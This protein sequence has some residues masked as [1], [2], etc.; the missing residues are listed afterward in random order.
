MVDAAIRGGLPTGNGSAAARR[1]T[2]AMV[3]G[4]ASGDLLASLMMGGL[5]ARLGDTMAYAGIGGKRMM[6]QG[7]ASRWP[8]ET[9]SVNGY[10]EVLGSLREILRTRRAVRDWLLAEPPQCF[11]GVDAPDFNFGLEVPLRRAGIPV[12]HF[13]SPSIWAWR[14]GRIRTIARAVDHILCLFP[15]EPE[16]YA[17]AGI[18]ATYVGHPLADVIPMVPDVAGARAELGLPAGHRVVAVLPGSRQSE[19]RNLG[20]TFFAAM[21]QM[22]RMDPNL[23]FVLPAASA[24][25]RAIVEDLHRQYPELRLTIVDG[26]S[27]QAMEAADVVLLASGTA[28]LEAA[29]YKKPMVISYKV[30]WL[31]AQIMKRQGY[32]PY[33]GLPNILSGR[34]VVPELLQDDATPEAL[35]RETLLQ[36]NDEGN[37]AFL[38]EHFTRMH[39]TLKCNT[40]QLAADV[41]V[42]LMHSRGTV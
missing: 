13:V 21:A 3:A 24:P 38:Y 30:P 29:L 32:L 41:V 9:L 19:V 8:M 25:L 14:G 6:A 27:H 42:D 4:E 22:Q 23:A 12:V 2:I 39:E 20:A 16:I 18:P 35:A 36:L 34:F 17:K 11:I 5:K 15:F 10:V 1:G 26:K 33:V 31:T 28:T 37:I 7:F 40:A